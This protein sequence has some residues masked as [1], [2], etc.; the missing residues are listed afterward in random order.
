[1]DLLEAFRSGEIAGQKIKKALE[2]YPLHDV[3]EALKIGFRKLSCDYKS[4]S[5]M[6]PELSD[7][8]EKKSGEYNG[9]AKKL[10]LKEKIEYEGVVVPAADST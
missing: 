4:E 5:C 6:Y 7:S 1:M 10:S 9:F 3:R 2:L 8:L